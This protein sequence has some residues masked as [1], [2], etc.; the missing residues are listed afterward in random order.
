MKR[1]DFFRYWVQIIIFCT[2]FQYG[3]Y[4]LHKIQILNL[5]DEFLIIALFLILIFA[6]HSGSGSILLKRTKYDFIIISLIL[7]AILS[8]LLNQIPFINFLLGMKSYFIYFL[9]FYSIYWLNFSELHIKKILQFTL[10]L[11]YIEFIVCIV[12]LIQG[13]STHTLTLDS[14]Y[15]TFNGS[16]FFG[17]AIFILLYFSLYNYFN[18][19]KNYLKYVV[20]LS[21]LFILSSARF[22]IL[23]FPVVFL[24]L[25]LKTIVRKIR[26][27]RIISAIILIIL[28][29]VIINNSILSSYTGQEFY[30]ISSIKTHFTET[31]NTIYSGSSRNLWYSLTKENLEE[32]SYNPLIGFGVGM[33][34]S[35]TAYQF[36]P[37]TNLLIYN[38]YNQ[39]EAGFDAD[40]DSQIIPLWGELGYLGIFLFYIL[41]LTMLIRIIFITRKAKNKTLLKLLGSTTT[42]YIIFF[43][44]GFYMHHMLE[45]QT[46]AL[47]LFMFIAFTESNYYKYKKN[48]FS[49]EL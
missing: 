48:I 31:E 21:I 40:I 41:L 15:G 39:I 1:I 20:L 9:L 28:F 3:F 12:Q 17:Y 27:R 35:F 5:V 10:K 13:I 4:R 14:I 16:N 26:S 34:A 25:N 7:L 32:Y 49:E 11:F 46:T 23:L 2:F 22:A 36:M 33:Y 43:I 18:G 47:L 29:I 44:V 24:I 19:E 30:K 38:Y 42:A 45:S 8:S 6:K 37:T